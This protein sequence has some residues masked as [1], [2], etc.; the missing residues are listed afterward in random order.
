MVERSVS[1]FSGSVE[2]DPGIDVV[3]PGRKSTRVVLGLSKSARTCL[4]GPGPP[5]SFAADEV[6]A[7]VSLLLDLACEKSKPPACGQRQ[8]KPAT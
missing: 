7:P 1:I 3:R 6:S 2:N 5:R 4:S 8:D